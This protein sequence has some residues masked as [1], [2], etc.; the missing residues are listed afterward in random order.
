MISLPSLLSLVPFFIAAAAADATPCTTGTCTYRSGDGSTSAWSILAI[1]TEN[2]TS[3]SDITDAAGWDIISCDPYST[4]PQDIRLVC[5]DRT[6]GCDQLFEGGEENTII[7]LPE[8]CAGGPFARVVKSWIPDDQTL[9]TR[10]AKRQLDAPVRALT[11]DF[12]F[13]RIPVSN[14]KVWITASATNSKAQRDALSQSAAKRSLGPLRHAT[15][16]GQG[17]A[18]V[19][20]FVESSKK[21][22]ATARPRRGF[23]DDVLGSAGDA[24]NSAG[25]AISGAANDAVD[26]VSGAAGQVGDT[27]QD[28]GNSVVDGAQDAVGAV[29]NGLG[30]AGDSIGQIID[31]TTGA[32]KDFVE[33]LDDRTSFN[34][35]TSNSFTALDIDQS[36]PVLSASLACPGNGT[37]PAFDAS[38]AVTAAVKAKIDADVGFI[39]TGSIVPPQIND[40][41]FTSNLR[42]NVVAAFDVKASAQG[43][44][45]TGLIPLLK[46]GLP[47]LSF[48]GILT[49][50]PSIS[51]NAQGKATLGITADIKVSSTF[52]LPQVNLVFPPSQGQSAAQ[53]IPGST[54]IKVDVGTSVELKGRAEVHIIPRLDIGVEIL[55]GAAKTTVFLNVDGSA[56]VDFSLSAGADFTPVSGTNELP[57]VELKD[58]E[59]KFG[60]TVGADVGININAGATAALVPFFDQTVSVPLFSKTFPIFTK[61][62]GQ[63]AVKRSLLDERATPADGLICPISFDVSQPIL[64]LEAP[65]P[66]Q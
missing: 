29:E 44:F 12:D 49:V 35:S 2:P 6:K 56:G 61:T 18:I 37:R 54:P 47:G 33:S 40:L 32:V 26:A 55:N 41:A 11:L 21:K 34:E 39:V 19:R 57:V 36:F 63:P 1:N 9:P 25:N 16:S 50:G 15:R 53:V 52:D 8:N 23:F 58:V 46:T 22:R 48:P 60:G 3:L 38:I 13:S 62:F 27:L 51:L 65:A 28:F 4:G 14:G 59:T 5:V 30:S 24:L 20:D 42:G 43:T 17:H 64:E 31:T 66:P 45:D 7:R 10:L